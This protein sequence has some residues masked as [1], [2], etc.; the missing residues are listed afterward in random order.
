MATNLNIDAADLG[1]V[2]LHAG[3]AEALTAVL[4][5]WL[6]EHHGTQV[7]GIDMQVL[8]NGSITVMITHRRNHAGRP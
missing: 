4:D 3:T 6:G 1:V 2:A 7:L 8:P 5:K